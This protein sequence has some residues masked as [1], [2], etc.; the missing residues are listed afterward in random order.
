L[1]YS[2]NSGVLFG[3]THAHSRKICCNDFQLDTT[4][5]LVR[6]NRKI[7]SAYFYSASFVKVTYFYYL[8]ASRVPIYYFK[9]M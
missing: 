6:I 9:Y 4:A 7:V 5:L 3:L 8:Y 2:I 1:I